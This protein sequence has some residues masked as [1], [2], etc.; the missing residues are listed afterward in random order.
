M[1]SIE[2]V[3]RPLKP[4]IVGSDLMVGLRPNFDPLFLTLSHLLP[5]RD[6]DDCMWLWC[7]KVAWLAERGYSGV[8]S[9]VGN[10]GGG[11]YVEG[12]ACMRRL[13]CWRASIWWSV[14]NTSRLSSTRISH[15]YDLLARDHCNITH[16]TYLNVSRALALR[17]VK[18][19]SVFRNLP[20]LTSYK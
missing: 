9:D 6:P 4:A 2:I 20:Q 11:R 7:S 15:L 3:L 14:L 5:N 10:G 8:S 13:R 19:S 18:S 1:S 16:L 12:P 17:K